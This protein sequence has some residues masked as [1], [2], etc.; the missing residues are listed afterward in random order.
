M[1]LEQKDIMC[2]L[3]VFLL[4]VGIWLFNNHNIS[5]SPE[6]FNDCVYN[7]IENNGFPHKYNNVNNFLPNN[8]NSVPG[9]NDNCVTA[10]SQSEF[11]TQ[12]LNKEVKPYGYFN[13]NIGYVPKVNNVVHPAVKAALDKVKNQH[14]HH[15]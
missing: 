13:Q 1:K 8:G 6:H 10:L 2:I 7:T 11:C 3:F 12:G 5:V 15:N 4:L 14:L 9:S